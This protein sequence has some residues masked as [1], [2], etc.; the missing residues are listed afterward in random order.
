MAGER[1]EVRWD[2]G[3][4]SQKVKQ[5]TRVGPGARV[6]TPPP[7]PESSQKLPE[8]FGQH[9]LLPGWTFLPPVAI[10]N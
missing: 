6:A 9:P 2:A 10:L 4:G 8:V 5:I 1:W 3:V 7:H